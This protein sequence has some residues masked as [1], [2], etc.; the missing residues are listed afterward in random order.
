VSDNPAADRE[1][2]ALVTVGRF[3]DPIAAEFARSLLEADGLAC[4]IQGGGLGAL[5]PTA[6]VYPI[7]LQVAAGDAAR[8]AE[9]LAQAPDPG[10]A[11]AQGDDGESDP[12]T[13]LPRA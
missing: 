13:E 9:V 7:L 10:A 8:A 2:D 11:D 4:Y 12:P 1:G 5:L 3:I 6:T